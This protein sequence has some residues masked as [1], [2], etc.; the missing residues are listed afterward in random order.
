M[1]NKYKYVFEVFTCNFRNMSVPGC[2]FYANYLPSQEKSKKKRCLFV[3]QLSK[4]F[5]AP[6]MSFAFSQ[7]LWNCIE[8]MHQVRGVKVKSVLQLCYFFSWSSSVI[9][10]L[11]CSSLLFYS[12]HWTFSKLSNPLNFKSF[13]RTQE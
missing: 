9:H 11:L 10:C 3:L 12:T 5:F 7:D 13:S 4:D 2:V 1:E 8:S 6:Q